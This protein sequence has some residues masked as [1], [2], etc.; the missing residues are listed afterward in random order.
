M[1]YKVNKEILGL[2][3]PN[4]ISN[5]SVP[6]ISAVDT[7]L[8]GGLSINH[9]GAVG[10]GAMI[11]NF[12]YWNFG[13]LRMGTTGLTAQEYGRSKHASGNKILWRSVSI[14][15]IISLIILTLCIPLSHFSLSLLNV[16]DS[17]SPLVE[18]YFFIRIWAAPATLT[19][20]VLMG[21]FFGKQNAVLPLIITVI[22]NVVNLIFSYIFVVHLNWDIAGV[23]YG[24]VIAQYLGVFIAFV[25]I[26][27]KYPS[28]VIKSWPNI[29]GKWKEW[30]MLFKVNAY[31][32]VRTVCLTFAFGFFYS[33]S[34]E[35]GAIILATNVVLLQFLNWLSYGIDGFA[36]ASESLVGK[37]YGA[38]QS[39]VLSKVVNIS[40]LWGLGIAVIFSFLYYFF[41][42]HFIRIFT[43]DPF[44]FA[45]AR[46]QKIWMVILPVVVFACY[47][48]DGIFIGLTEVK[49]MM[50]SMLISL[51]IYLGYYYGLV[52]QGISTLWMALIIFLFIR[53]ILQSIIWCKTIKHQIQI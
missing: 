1:K 5:I 12:L 40:F 14:A 37:Y 41:D 23:A 32:F 52:A 11:F 51:T 25:L 7:A 42:F 29:I 47:I 16:S 22:V 26:W 19:L 9:L 48:W 27:I 53:G 6:L 44:V 13:F 4:I 21:W 39:H 24:T 8:M 36:F 46:E 33:K 31:L 3:I 20:Y 34:S 38:K 50:I 35:G 18:E 28:I 15:I 45:A 17:Q 2:A 49:W 43:D 10:L 30:G